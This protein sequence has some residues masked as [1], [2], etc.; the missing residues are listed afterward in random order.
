MN[1]VI[2]F[3]PTEGTKRISVYACEYL[4]CP[5]ID[6]TSFMS[7]QNFDY[8]KEYEYL[9][10][11]FPVYSQNIPLPVIEILKRIKS[12]YFL[13]LATYGKMQMGNALSE[14]SKLA[15]GVV[16]GGA[17]IPTKHTYKD[18]D[19]YRDYKQLDPL[20]KRVKDK[21]NMKAIFPKLKKNV[22]ANEFPNF[23]SRA[24]VKIIRTDE[25]N[26]CNLC[27]KFCPMNSINNGIINKGCI[28]CLSCYYHCPNKGLIVRY[29]KLLK[30]Y[31]KNDKI[32]NLI[33][34]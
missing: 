19:Y 12:R 27:N 18:G 26:N 13:L 23:R 21:I 9:V 3:S 16:I 29:H 28:R 33:L 24:G 2:C 11:C 8:S 20:L 1:S 15:N 4:N 22:F 10:I 5:L 30:R 14:A 34:Y 31:L 32:E 6:H 7:R 17:Y 25:C